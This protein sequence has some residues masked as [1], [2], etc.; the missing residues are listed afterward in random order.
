MSVD[1]TAVTISPIRSKYQ[2]GDIIKCSAVGRPTP[3]ITWIPITAGLKSVS[4]N[5][6]ASLKVGK[7]GTNRWLCTASNSKNLV[8]F[9]GSLEYGFSFKKNSTETRKKPNYLG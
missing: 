4:G 9:T 8:T 1:A 2:V 5:G 6:K 7:L 3:T